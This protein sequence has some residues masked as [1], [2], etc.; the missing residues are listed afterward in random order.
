MVAPA[1]QEEKTMAA[2]NRTKAVLT[3]AAVAMAS[4]ALATTSTYAAIS[5]GDVL[6]LDLSNTGDADGGSL[7]DW[8]QLS[9]NGT[10]ADGSVIRHGDG[11]VV[12]GVT[13]TLAGR[14][15]NNNDVNA[16]N[17]PGMA[18][19]PYYIPA[20]DD[21]VY[22][23][24]G[25]LLTVTFAGLDDALSYNARVYSL[26]NENKAAIN[27]GVTDGAGTITNTG[28][29]RQTLY[30]TA[31]LSPNLIFNG[32]STDGSGNI[33]ATVSSTWHVNMEAVVLEAVPEP[34]T[35]SLLA[36]GGLGVFFRRRRRA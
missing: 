11:A 33:V 20:A 25:Y 9:T 23:T 2:R 12:D 18:G 5:A 17:W 8:N 28:L 24:T 34:A 10:I 15:G 16:A 32:V 1:I 22:S 4:L 14:L 6:K 31:P 21:L 27:V 29:N 19:D 26:V 36:L 30:N 13:I 7:A 3:L 35:M